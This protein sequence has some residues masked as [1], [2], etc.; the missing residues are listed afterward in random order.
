MHTRPAAATRPGL[1]LAALLAVMLLGP[2]GAMAQ[3]DSVRFRLAVQRGE[4]PRE[5]RVL[6]VAHD[7]LVRLEFLADRPLVI[8]LEGY[9]LSVHAEPGTPEVIEFKAFATGRFSVHAHEVDPQGGPARHAS[10]ARPL[11]RFEVHPK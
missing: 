5:Q 1:S 9:D 4:V 2:G 6:K 8:H 7:S 10:H 3:S 11:L